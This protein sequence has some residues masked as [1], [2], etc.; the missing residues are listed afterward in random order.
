MNISFDRIWQRNMQIMGE[1]I[2]DR[3]DWIGSVARF[4]IGARH[5]RRVVPLAIAPEAIPIEVVNTEI[6]LSTLR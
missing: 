6:P 2:V 5:D 3:C 1:L 4:G